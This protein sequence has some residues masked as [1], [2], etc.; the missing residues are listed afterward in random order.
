MPLHDRWAGFKCQNI[1]ISYFKYIVDDKNRYNKFAK[2][3]RR[4]YDDKFSF[5]GDRKGIQPC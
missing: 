4:Q 1:R 5:I 2:A 3:F